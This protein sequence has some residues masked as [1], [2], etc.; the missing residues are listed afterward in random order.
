M[1]VTSEARLVT[2]EEDMDDAGVKLNGPGI[3]TT[4]KRLV[5]DVHL[6]QKPKPY[7]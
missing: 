1:D 6:G 5:W 7:L 4:R 3:P 2:V